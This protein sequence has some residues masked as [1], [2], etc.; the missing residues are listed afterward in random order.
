[1]AGQGKSQPNTTPPQQHTNTPPQ[2]HSSKHHCEHHSQQHHHTIH[3]AHEL[4]N[5][6]GFTTTSTASRTKPANQSQDDYLAKLG[7]RSSS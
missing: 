7:I 1:L 4:T 6:E 2:H 3:P 5:R